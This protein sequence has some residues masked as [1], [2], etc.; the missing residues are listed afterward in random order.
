M[1]TAAIGINASVRRTALSRSAGS[2]AESRRVM[3]ARACCHAGRPAPR[4]A[5]R[6]GRRSS[7]AEDVRLAK[8][9]DDTVPR[10]GLEQL[11]RP[12][13][14]QQRKLAAAPRRIARREDLESAHGQ[15]IQEELQEPR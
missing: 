14:N 15:L 10:Q 6:V 5:F 8:V 4:K 12:L 11:A 7:D 9:A 3:T 2:S 13:V 1:S